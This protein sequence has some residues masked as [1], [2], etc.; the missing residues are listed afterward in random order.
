[1]QVAAACA[2]VGVRV[3]SVYGFALGNFHRDPQEVR[4]LLGLA[5]ALFR[6]PQ[7]IQ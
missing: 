3:V 7:W 6:D 1:M 5:E 4:G 2:A